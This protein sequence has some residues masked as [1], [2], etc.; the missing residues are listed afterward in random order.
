MAPQSKVI[1]LRFILSRFQIAC[2]GELAVHGINLVGKDE[3]MKGAGPFLGRAGKWTARRWI[4]RHVLDL[5][6]LLLFLAGIALL[7]IGFLRSHTVGVD[8]IV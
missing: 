6:I 5:L 2:S 4:T 8:R 1:G 3:I 7:L